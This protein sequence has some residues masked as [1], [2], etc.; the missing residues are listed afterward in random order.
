MNISLQQ[1][2]QALQQAID[3][4][5]EISVP[6]NIVIV[7]NTGYLKAFARM[8]DALLG[9]IDIALQKAKT[10]MLFRMDT[11]AVGDFLQPG[12][13]AYGLELTNGGLLGFAGG[14]PI[15]INGQ[16]AG[17]IGISGGAI[18]QDAQ[19]AQAGSKL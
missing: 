13:K 11:E 9:S 12:A 19:I 2:N 5:V 6:V 7:D 4:A 3:K 18:T 8:D 17:F 15:T 10:S 14:K 1:A 16:V